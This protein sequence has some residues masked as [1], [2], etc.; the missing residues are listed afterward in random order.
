MF[1]G[2]FSRRMLCAFAL[3]TSSALADFPRSAA[4]QQGSSVPEREPLQS[5]PKLP[6]AF[7]EACRSHT[8]GEACSV[9]F[10]THKL[11]GTCRKAPGHDD[12]ACLPAGPPPERPRD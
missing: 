10:Q 1:F 7:L 11:S 3:T 12:L 8:E 5:A 6:Q 2:T 4:H 9:E